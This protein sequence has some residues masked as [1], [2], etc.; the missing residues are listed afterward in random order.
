MSPIK[1]QLIDVIDYLPEKEQ[2]LLLEIAKR[3]VSDDVATQDDI[4]SI[5][6]ARKEYENGETTDH[7]AINWD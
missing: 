4:L 2:T 7:N 1:K 6:T 5:Q 3:F